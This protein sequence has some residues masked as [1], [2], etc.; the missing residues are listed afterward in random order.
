MGCDLQSPGKES[1]GQ[2]EEF[3]PRHGSRNQ[4]LFEI[5]HVFF[6]SSNAK[7]LLTASARSLRFRAFPGVIKLLVAQRGRGAAGLTA[8]PWQG[9]CPKPDEIS[10]G[11][12]TT[13]KMFATSATTSGLQIPESTPGASPVPVNVEVQ[14]WSVVL[15]E[16]FLPVPLQPSKFFS[17]I[18]NFLQN[19]GL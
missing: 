2:L 7:I 16:V 17:C 4:S 8:S 18:L 12:Q 19:W 14:V 3:T 9:G 10:L 1:Q 6:K 15:S 5:C 11:I 13:F